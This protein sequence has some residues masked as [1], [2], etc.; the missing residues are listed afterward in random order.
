[1]SEFKNFFPTKLDPRK[2]EFFTSNSRIKT[3]IRYT[4]IYYAFSAS[5]K[6]SLVQG[7]NIQKFSTYLRL[8]LKFLLR[9]VSCV[10]YRDFDRNYCDIVIIT[11]NGSHMEVR[12]RILPAGMNLF[13]FFF[14]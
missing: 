5:L 12:F 11:S 2:R 13:F 9:F 6:I 8:K 4:R 10:S 7:V 14:F 1:M 3:Y